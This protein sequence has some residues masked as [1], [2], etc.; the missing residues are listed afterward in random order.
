[1]GYELGIWK[2]LHKFAKFIHR[3]EPKTFNSI[4]NGKMFGDFNVTSSA[5]HEL[6]GIC[7]D[8]SRIVT[9]G[10]K[11]HLRSHIIPGSA[12]NTVD[13]QTSANN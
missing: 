7:C 13:M 5:K 10:W 11:Y 6:R 1:M 4:L 3:C 8:T 2:K 12:A 9:W